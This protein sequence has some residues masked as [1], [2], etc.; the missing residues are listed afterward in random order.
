MHYDVSDANTSLC[1]ATRGINGETASENSHV[2][3]KEVPTGLKSSSSPEPVNLPGPVQ[4][5]QKAVADLI[6]PVEPVVNSST[7]R[8][9]VTPTGENTLPIDPIP[10]HE[11]E[12]ALAEENPRGKI[13]RAETTD[14]VQ[15]VGDVHA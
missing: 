7:E 9:A 10:E 5:A 11:E 6:E 15:I 13:S 12:D 1:R 2:E 8:V 3:A 4:E 14:S